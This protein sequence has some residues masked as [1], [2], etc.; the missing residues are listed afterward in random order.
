MPKPSAKPPTSC[1]MEPDGRPWRRSSPCASAG[2]CWTRLARCGRA[3]HGWP[4]RRRSCRTA[5]QIPCDGTRSSSFVDGAWADHSA[6]ARCNAVGHWAEAQRLAER[7]FVQT[8]VLTLL[9]GADQCTAR[10]RT[11][12]CCAACT[13]EPSRS[14]DLRLFDALATRLASASGADRVRVCRVARARPRANL[15][16]APSPCRSCRC[17]MAM[18]LRGLSADLR[19]H[20]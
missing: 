4:L 12:G 13:R 9:A 16:M 20:A 15:R 18:T 5:Y 2:A 6:P 10:V 7:A 19:V 17:Q 11:S 1:A 8:L 14:C 3:H